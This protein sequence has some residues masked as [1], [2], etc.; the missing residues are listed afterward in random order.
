[1]WDFR[2]PPWC[3]WGLHSSVCYTAYVCSWLLT[4]QKS[5]LMLITLMLCICSWH[6]HVTDN[7]SCILDLWMHLK[8]VWS[9]LTLSTAPTTGKS[10]LKREQWIRL[11]ERLHLIG[12]LDRIP[13]RLVFYLVFYLFFLV[14]DTLVVIVIIVIV[15]KCNLYWLFSLCYFL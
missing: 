12:C 10:S 14:F 5:A 11:Q 3:S 1:M 8:K 9:L 2:L 6:I 13:D 15:V 4:F 7:V